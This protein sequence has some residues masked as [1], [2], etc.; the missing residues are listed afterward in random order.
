MTFKVGRLARLTSLRTISG[1]SR[2]F[3]WQPLL[4]RPLQRKALIV[5]F[6]KVKSFLMKELLC[7]LAK[8]TDISRL[9]VQQFSGVIFLCG[10]ATNCNGADPTSARDFFLRRIKEKKPELFERIFLAEEINNWAD[11]MVQERYTPDLLTLESHVS[12]LVSA[13]SLIVESPGSIAELG[14]FC[15]L[16][17]VPERLMV[18]VR[19]E[20]MQEPSFIS[21]GP[22]ARLRDSRQ[23]DTSPVYV[24]PW[25]V[26]WDCD[27]ETLLPNLDD[28]SNHADQFIDDLEEFEQ[29]LPKSQ[30]FDPDNEGH[31]SLLIGDLIGTFS[32]LL[33]GE[34]VSCLVEIGVKK[35]DQNRVKGHVFLLEKLGFIKKAAYRNRDYYTTQ[36][37]FSFI[38]YNRENPPTDLRDY[39]RFK[40]KVTEQLNIEGKRLV[41]IKQAGCPQGEG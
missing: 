18:V 30:K 4:C 26:Q 28:L 16:A 13:V 33:I 31:L 23:E 41:A 14:S 15:L 2:A 9:R 19:D 34:I 25:R 8:H 27:S 3:L 32:A 35:I 40:F 1:T 12:G 17:G 10:G 22:I 29:K 36:T 20:W 11:H 24:Y 21:L 5:P 37:D 38:E 39:S 7:L 6:S